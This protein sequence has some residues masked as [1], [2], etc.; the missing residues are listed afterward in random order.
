[1]QRTKW[2]DLIGNI[3]DG[4]TIPVRAAT[5]V[6]GEDVANATWTVLQ[7]PAESIAGRVLNCSDIVVSHRRIVELVHE[8]ANV[9][10]PVPEEGEHPAGI[11]RCDALQALGVRFGGEPL[12]EAT[13]AEIVAAAREARPIR[14]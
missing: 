7:A 6:H 12:F 1:V 11:M 10:G 13:I 2:F 14:S 5:E 4:A 3:L 9:D 8:I